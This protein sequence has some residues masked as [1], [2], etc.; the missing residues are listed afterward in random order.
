MFTTFTQVLQFLKE[1]G[2]FHMDLSLH[3][4][5]N[6]LEMLDLTNPPFPIVQLVG[7]N[8][9]GSTAAFLESVA[10]AHGLRTGLYT[11]PYFIS[12]E[13]SICLDGQGLNSKQWPALAT[14]IHAKAPDLTHFEFLTVLAMLAFTEAKVDVAI[15]EAGLG[16]QYDATTALPRHV[17][18]VTPI[19]MEHEKMLGPTLQDIAKHK[20]MAMAA[21]MQ[22]FSAKQESL[23]QNI[24]AEYAQE[25]GAHFCP[26]DVE[27]MLPKKVA[28][29]LFGAHQRE[30]ATLAVAAWQALD[31]QFF[32]VY[33]KEK[34]LQGLAQ[35]FISGRFQRIDLDIGTCI[36]DG[37]HNVAGLQS[38]HAALQD[39]I[40]LQYAAPKA[41]VFSCLADKN[42]QAMLSHI[43]HI[44]KFCSENCSI[45]IP[46]QAVKERAMNQ[47]QREQMAQALGGIL[48]EN[49]NQAVQRACAVKAQKQQPVL[50]FGSLYLLGEFFAA[51]AP[52]AL[53]HR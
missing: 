13:E 7:T 8:G 53:Q 31:A 49:V 20:A 22:V 33:N 25:C 15:I 52:W 45:F 16:G 6:A 10:R 27:S 11:S 50:V 35:A 29:G 21:Q 4:V 26:V 48:C 3:R 38:L 17:L 2:Q 18:C 19:S 9:K 40:S 12:P 5:H 34:M 42:W 32:Q 14:K 44:Q 39:Y 37:A 23:V 24:L 47:M 28:L 1:R 30:N 43:R 46:A 41:I 51:Y 36:V